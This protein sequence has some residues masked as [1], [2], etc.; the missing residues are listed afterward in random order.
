VLDN[1]AV[2]IRPS[3]RHVLPRFGIAPSDDTMRA[4][5]DKAARTGVA[6]EINPH[7]HP[8]PWR[9]VEWCKEA[10]ARISLGSNAHSC[11]EVGRI[12]RVLE[13]REPARALS[14]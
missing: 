14:A 3:L 4:V 7:Y 9:I 10:G 11:E 13:G 12:T 2:D 1:P 5:I 6:I 8:D